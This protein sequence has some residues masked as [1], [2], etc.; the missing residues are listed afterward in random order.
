MKR[1]IIFKTE[2][3]NTPLNPSTVSYHRVLESYQI[4]PDGSKDECWCVEHDEGD[5]ADPAT[6][7]LVIGVG[8]DPDS[9]RIIWRDAIWK[10]A[11]PS[12]LHLL[13]TLAEAASAAHANRARKRANGAT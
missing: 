11:T 12:Q 10:P 8:Q 5:I 2:E 13:T 7:P 4:N 6:D 9:P 3:A 1:L